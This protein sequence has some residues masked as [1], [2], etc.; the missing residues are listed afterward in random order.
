VI[1]K[2][3]TISVNFRISPVYSIIFKIK[4]LQELST[5]GKMNDVESAVA[6]YCNGMTEDQKKMFAIKY[7]EGK[8]D[9]LVY[10][11]LWFFLGLIGA[12]KFYMGK[13]G[14]GVAY[15]F[16]GGFLAIGW[17]ID[18]FAGANEVKKYNEQVAMKVKLILK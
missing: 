6:L 4:L 5:G 9:V 18:L 11:L 8:K 7:G 10:Y 16:T 12:H 13:V 15:L 14:L 1:N 17:F 2:I 3:S